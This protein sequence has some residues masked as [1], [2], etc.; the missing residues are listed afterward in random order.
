LVETRPGPVS[1]PGGPTVIAILGQGRREQALVA[2]AAGGGKDGLPV[3]FDP[4][5]SPDGRHFQTAVRPVIP[6]TIEVFINPKGDGTDLPLVQI[7][8]QAMAD[9]WN[10]EFTDTDGSNY[11][12]VVPSEYEPE[13]AGDS[14]DGYRGASDGTGFF[15]SKFARQFAALKQRLGITAGSPEP[16]HYIFDAA[17]GRIVLDQPLR[18]FDTLIVSYIAESD[19]NDPELMFSLKDVIAKHGFP[20]KMN[21]ISLAAQIAFENGAGVVMPVH[22][23]QVL[24]GEGSAKRLIAEPT[25]F[26]ALKSLEK[27]ELVEIVVPVMQSRVYD[28]VIMPFYEAL[29]HGELTDEG[30]FLQEAEEE[31]DQ[32]GI[33]ISP[34]ALDAAGEAPRFL[35]VFKNGRK[36]QYGI[37]YS[38]PN[39]GG[40]PAGPNESRNVLIA[41]DPE[42]E[43]A[44]HS[45]DNTL[46]EGDRITASYLP[47]PD[48]INLVATSQLAVLQHCNLMS[49]TKNRLERTCLFG[50]YEFVDLQFII[51]G[52]TG[53]E[54]NFGSFFRSM[55]F[56]PGGSS[57]TRVVAGEAQTLDAQY[58]AAA[59]AGYV[60]SRP[61]PT[62]LTN[63]ILQGFTIN[64]RQKLNND[65]TNLVGGSGCAIVTPLAA[66]GKVLHGRTTVNSGSAVEEEYSIIRIRDHVAKTVRRALEN[67][68]V[69]RL[70]TATTSDDVA[71]TTKNILDALVSQGIISD[72]QNVDAF[73]DPQEPRQ[74]DVQF[75]IRPVFP[76]N[77]IFIKFT[78]GS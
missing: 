13:T 24:Q 47:A 14:V 57:V 23:G 61:I 74:I 16:N 27:E 11:P 73:V 31:G 30:R 69:G 26:T 4:A 66:G 49:E 18:P 43:G 52:T 34:L 20:S 53:I 28:E 51:N 55:F 65:E 63:K 78:V 60:A 6:G 42:Y 21:T 41:L 36:L 39:L 12:L 19:L 72:Y 45:V 22:A 9:A 58:I 77:W 71:V 5:N 46:Q 56:F 2:R 70:I 35:E 54:A 29:V 25:L 59:A 40:T 44:T 37:D 15:D 64:P 7:T 76:L 8:N 48:V 32:P 10:L 67:T 68:F 75:D 1:L 33:N 50:A 17:T 3:K 38:I 62:P